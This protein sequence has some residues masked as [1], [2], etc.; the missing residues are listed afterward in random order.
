MVTGMSTISYSRSI[1]IVDY[2]TQG[3]QLKHERRKK[4]PYNDQ[5]IG[6]RLKLYRET[7]VINS[8]VFSE[9]LGISQGSLSDTETNKR[10]PPAKSLQNISRNTDLNI[11]WLYT[12]EGNMIRGPEKEAKEIGGG[13]SEAE[14]KEWDDKTKEFYLLRLEKRLQELEDTTIEMKKAYDN[15]KL[16]EKIARLTNIMEILQ[17]LMMNEIPPEGIEIEF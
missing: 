11:H 6:G 15:Q 3:F 12:G 8:K 4:I 10:F 1:S 5:T 17:N 2:S 13:D 9:L 7:K 16:V 14:V